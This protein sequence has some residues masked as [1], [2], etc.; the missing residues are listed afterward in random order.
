[1]LNLLHRRTNQLSAQERSKAIRL[2][3]EDNELKALDIVE[4]E[5]ARYDLTSDP[6]GRAVLVMPNKVFDVVAKQLNDQK[7]AFDVI[8]V[9]SM[10]T[11]PADVRRR[12]RH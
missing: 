3:D 7:I 10:S 11:L 12:V 4:A 6:S 9:R 1:M 8:Q 2:L 5:G